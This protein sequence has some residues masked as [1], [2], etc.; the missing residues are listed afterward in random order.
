MRRWSTQTDSFGE[1][2]WMVRLVVWLYKLSLS[3][4][5]QEPIEE[6]T[7]TSDMR[8]YWEWVEVWFYKL[9]L[10]FFYKNEWRNALQLSD[11]RHYWESG[12]AQW[13][14]TV[15]NNHL[16]LVGLQEWTYLELPGVCARFQRVSACVCAEVLVWCIFASRQA[17]TTNIAPWYEKRPVWVPL[18]LSVDWCEVQWC[19]LGNCTSVHAAL[20]P[21]NTDRTPKS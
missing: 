3:F 20:T 14:P 8:R 1:N 21:W 9:W 5:W 19:W 10:S 2:L 13:C 6:C 15:S 18:N 12:S 4:F 11:K 16:V 17:T 7:P